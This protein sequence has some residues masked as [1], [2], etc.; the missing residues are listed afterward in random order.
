[1]TTAK[2]QKYLD[3]QKKKLENQRT[4]EEREV[5]TVSRLS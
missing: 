4:K 3:K 2:R 5:E 1:M